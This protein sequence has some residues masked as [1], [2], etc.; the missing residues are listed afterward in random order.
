MYMRSSN[1]SSVI[2]LLLPFRNSLL[3]VFDS[4]NSNSIET[5]NL[6]SLVFKPHSFKNT[7][8]LIIRNMTHLSTLTIDNDCFAAGST[9]VLDSWFSFSCLHSV[10]V[11]ELV[12]FSIGGGV[13]KSE[14][15]AC[16]ANVES[17]TFTNLPK[18]HEFA[19]SGIAF[20]NAVNVSITSM[21]SLTSFTLGLSLPKLTLGENV[22]G[23]CKNFELKSM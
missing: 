18:I 20:P 8:E 7:H 12:N 16:F 23:K 1:L 21:A 5:P 19:V 15:E 2:L 3:M 17:V 22:F 11:P 9:F 14:D 4:F 10:D 6:V 13:A